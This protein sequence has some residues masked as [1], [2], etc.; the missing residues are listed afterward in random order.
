MSTLYSLM[1]LLIDVGAKVSKSS[2]LFHIPWESND[3][4]R[5]LRAS[6]FNENRPS[7]WTMQVINSS[8]TR[9]S[10]LFWSSVFLNT[11]NKYWSSWDAETGNLVPYKHVDTQGFPLMNLANFEEIL[12]V[13]SSMA[14]KGSYFFG[15]L[16]TWLAENEVNCCISV[17][18]VYI[19]L[20]SPASRD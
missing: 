20:L 14:I 18:C 4:Q 8:S 16:P 19:Y 11:T 7:I 9:G 3:K 6:G 2:L 12:S 1:V 17:H 5:D 13:V 15:E 10:Q